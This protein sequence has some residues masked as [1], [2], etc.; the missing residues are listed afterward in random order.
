MGKAELNSRSAV[1]NWIFAS[2]IPLLAV[3][4]KWQ[5]YAHKRKWGVLGGSSSALAPWSVQ[6][7]I[8]RTFEETQIVRHASD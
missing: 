6:V 3:K 2:F 1:D 5:L 4:I 8:P 7:E